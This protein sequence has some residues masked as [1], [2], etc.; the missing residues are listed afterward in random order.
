MIEEG[1]EERALSN[2]HP[3]MARTSTN[4][5]VSFLWNTE[6]RLFALNLHPSAKSG[7]A[8]SLAHLCG[9]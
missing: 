9:K 1:F 3:V 5:Q 4:F 7:F 6:I 2:P 8:L